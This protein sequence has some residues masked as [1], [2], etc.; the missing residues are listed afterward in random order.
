MVLQLRHSLILFVTAVQHQS[1]DQCPSSSWAKMGDAVN[2]DHPAT[3]NAQKAG[4][5]LATSMLLLLKP[6]LMAP[7]HESD[8]QK[9]APCVNPFDPPRRDNDSDEDDEYSVEDVAET[10]FSS[11][12]MLW[13]HGILPDDA[14]ER[15]AAVAA[16]V[17]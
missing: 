9:C 2:L 13:S 11:L 16:A 10:V 3:V 15:M 7:V 6:L 12:G 4:N 17:E 14:L 5:I 1:Q 8:E